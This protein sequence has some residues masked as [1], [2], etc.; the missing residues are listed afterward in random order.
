MSHSQKP[1]GSTKFDSSQ[2]PEQ[3][4]KTPK[5]AQSWQFK[6]NQRESKSLVRQDERGDTFM[7]GSKRM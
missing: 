3:R 7:L 2:S 6:G 5:T 4:S 1:I